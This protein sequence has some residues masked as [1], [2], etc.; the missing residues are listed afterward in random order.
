MQIKQCPLCTYPLR[1]AW[2]E[3]G[4]KVITFCSNRR[5]DYLKVRSSK[6]VK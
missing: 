5:C 4:K 6:N 2:S 1:R 3:D